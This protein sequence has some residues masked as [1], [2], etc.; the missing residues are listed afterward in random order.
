MG[1]AA[2]APLSAIALMI[3]A[4]PSETRPAN[5][6]SQRA[7]LHEVNPAYVQLLKEK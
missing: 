3:K 7:S 6:C 4:A 5:V 1:A 2:V